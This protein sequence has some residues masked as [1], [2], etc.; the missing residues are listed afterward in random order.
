MDWVSPARSA[1][2]PGW[3]DAGRKGELLS[4]GEKGEKVEVASPPAGENPPGEEGDA[5]G[6]EATLVCTGSREVVSG[7]GATG[8]GAI[9]AASVS[10]ICCSTG[11]GM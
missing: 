8:A 7:T 1:P 5:T 9:S 3:R 4:A 11:G 10:G 6:G 2:R